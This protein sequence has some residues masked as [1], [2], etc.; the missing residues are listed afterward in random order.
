MRVCF[1]GFIPKGVAI[2]TI[3]KLVAFFVK[4]KVKS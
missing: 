4:I 1:R 3:K 2:E